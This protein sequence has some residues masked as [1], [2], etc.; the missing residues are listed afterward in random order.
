[1]ESDRYSEDLDQLRRSL[2]RSQFL[3]IG[4]V[5]ALLLALWN[6]LNMFGRDRTIVTPPTIEKSFWVTASTAAPAYVE[7]MTLWIASLILDVTPENIDY[8][9]TLL[10]QYAHPDAHGKLK[11]RQVLESQRLKRDNAV[12][13]FVLQ[14]IRSHPEKMAALVSGRL[15]TLING[16]HVADQDKNYLVRF[17]MDGGRAHLVAFQEAPHADLAKIL[18]DAP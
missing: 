11:E 8:K 4:L 5:L 16:N 17:R 1:M 7:Q 9:A 14:T 12:T 6:A 10:L 15:H 2:K 13:Y 18:E 3:S